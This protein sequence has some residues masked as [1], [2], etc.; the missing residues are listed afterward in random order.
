MTGK[1]STTLYQML[2]TLSISSSVVGSGQRAALFEKYI[3]LAT[4]KCPVHVQLRDSV[5]FSSWKR[6][7]FRHHYIMSWCIWIMSHLFNILMS[8]GNRL[9]P[10]LY[11]LSCHN[12]W[13]QTVVF[14]QNLNNLLMEGLTFLKTQ[15]SEWVWQGKL[16]FSSLLQWPEPEYQRLMH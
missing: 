11:P 8:M 10:H 4:S 7:D 2:L 16:R 6:L 15:R 9:Y 5:S 3:K 13:P 12:V 1:V 14:A